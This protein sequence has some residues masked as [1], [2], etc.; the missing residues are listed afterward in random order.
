[1]AGLIVGDKFRRHQAPRRGAKSGSCH[2]DRRVWELP[3]Q[4]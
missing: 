1:M 4:M 2:T 3:S